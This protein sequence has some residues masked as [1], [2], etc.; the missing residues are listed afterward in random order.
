MHIK[1]LVNL[2]ISIT[3]IFN[4]NIFLKFA[5]IESLLFFFTGEKD[6]S[7]KH[8]IMDKINKYFRKTKANGQEN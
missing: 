8:A 7:K 3:L 2:C 1:K 6:N 4:Y 5:L